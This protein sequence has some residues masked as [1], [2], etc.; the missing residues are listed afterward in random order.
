MKTKILIG[1]ILIS[2]AA[3]SQLQIG[4]TLKE[5]RDF[6]DNKG[7]LKMEGKFD[8]NSKYLSATYKGHSF[9][10]H[11]NANN[12]CI[13]ET[14]QIKEFGYKEWERLLF[15][16]GYILSE[17]VYYKYTAGAKAKLRYDEKTEMWTANFSPFE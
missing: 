9:V 14:Q 6:I 3:F 15:D 4:S 8:D 12:V 16:A 13:Y 7:Y 11:F 1:F 5:V 10:Y 2:Q 17:S